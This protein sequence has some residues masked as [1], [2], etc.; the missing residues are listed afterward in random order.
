MAS[1]PVSMKGSLRSVSGTQRE[2]T[3]VLRRSIW[4]AGFNLGGPLL[5]ETAGREYGGF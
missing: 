4:R 1:L 2:L 5:S 3:R